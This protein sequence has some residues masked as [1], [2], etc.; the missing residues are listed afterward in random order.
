M[1]VIIVAASTGNITTS[2]GQVTSAS[3]E[4][5]IVKDGDFKNG[6][7]QSA[8]ATAATCTAAVVDSDGAGT[9][10]CMVD[11]ADNDR[12]SYNVWC[13]SRAGPGTAPTTSVR[14]LRGI[15]RSFDL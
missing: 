7:G 3:L 8:R 4:A 11:F 1:L 9:Y 14:A 2:S 10:R 15:T 5:S 13:T 6:A 12:M